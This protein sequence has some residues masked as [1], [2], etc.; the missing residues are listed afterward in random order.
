MDLYNLPYEVLFNILVNLSAQQLISICTISTY[1]REICSDETLWKRL[2]YDKYGVREKIQE[3][4]SWYDNYVYIATLFKPQ[5]LE[6]ILKLKQLS[7]NHLEYLKLL[8]YYDSFEYTKNMDVN[9]KIEPKTIP[10]QSVIVDIE[11]SNIN[12]EEYKIYIYSLGSNYVKWDTFYYINIQNTHLVSNG[13]IY[14]SSTYRHRLIT[15][16][17]G[18]IITDNVDNYYVILNKLQLEAL[19]H[20]YE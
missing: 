15:R 13:Y 18:E 5:E 16:T 12:P 4:K 6:I 8:S 7:P 2:I 20:M 9:F 3:D 19:S 1:G 14:P 17:Y 10:L 11:Q